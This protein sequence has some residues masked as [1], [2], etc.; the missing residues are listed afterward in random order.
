MELKKISPK[1]VSKLSIV[2]PCYNEQDNI[3]NLYAAVKKE[4][5]SLSEKYEF[6]HI[7]IDNHSV[8]KTPDILRDLAQK[9]PNV[10]VILNA[11]NF[12]HIRS[13]YYGLMQASGDAVMLVVADLQDPPHLIPNFIQKW[14]EGFKIVVGV[15]RTSGE[16][17][18]FYRIR[19]LYYRS[20]R[21]L[22]EV[23]IIEN[24]TGFGLY[25]RKVLDILKS[26]DDP[27]PFF[28]GLICEIGFEKA[29]IPYDQPARVRGFTKNNFYTLYDI[30][31]LGITSHS[32]KPL[33]LVAATGLVLSAISLTISII[34]FFYKLL[35]WNEFSLG[36]APLILGLF[37]F[38]SIQLLF[39]GIIGEYIGNI[40]VKIMNRPIVVERERINF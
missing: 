15:K 4:I 11:R 35:Y 12:G 16:N 7:F 13:P 1:K 38:S 17:S 26:L 9:D 30:G 27:Y 31:V 25:D 5:T 6:E 10:R 28:R 22:S 24:Y 29:I 14:E 34:Y 21:Y 40:Y 3:L 36:L 32:K 8:D 37:F 19:K 20:L 33:R 18:L 2:T 39:L 23:P